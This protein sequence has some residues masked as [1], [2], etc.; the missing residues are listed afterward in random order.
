MSKQITRTLPKT[1]NRE[2]L[3]ELNFTRSLLFEVYG[4]LCHRSPD[5]LDRLQRWK[6]QV[7]NYNQQLEHDISHVSWHPL[8]QNPS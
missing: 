1:A 4:L 6:I 8:H 5:D 3:A 7:A 2:L